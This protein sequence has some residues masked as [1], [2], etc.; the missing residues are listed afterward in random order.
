MPKKTTFKSVSLKSL[1]KSA[2]KVHA[3]NKRLARAIEKRQPRED[4][5]QS[6]YR[7]L[8]ETIRL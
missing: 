5:I 4:G 8:Q 2:N 3:A 7:T 6:A 1:K